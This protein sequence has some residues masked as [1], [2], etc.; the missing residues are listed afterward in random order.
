[1]TYNRNWFKTFKEQNG[2]IKIVDDS[3]HKI[4]GSGTM[5]I[6]VHNGSVR[7]LD[8][9]FVP[10]LQKNLISWHLGERWT[11]IFYKG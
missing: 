1:M 5:Q 4:K 11:K 3:M 8:W 7:T 9:W 10:N 6:K 2:T